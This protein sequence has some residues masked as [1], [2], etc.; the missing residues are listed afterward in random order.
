M[1]CFLPNSASSVLL[2]FSV[3]RLRFIPLAFL[4]AHLAPAQTI[5][6]QLYWTRL[7][8]SMP[9]N[10]RW[11]LRAE[12]DER[13]LIRP[14][15]QAQFIVHLQAARRL[16][17]HWE[18]GLTQTFS[19]VTRNIL[20]V[21]EWRPSSEITY[22][23]RIGARWRCVQRLRTEARWL[24]RNDGKLLLEGYQ[25]RARFRYRLQMERT[26]G[27]RWLLRLNDEIMV[28]HDGFDQNR[29]Y[30]SFVR[31]LSAHLSL[32]LGCLKVLQQRSSGG[33]VWQDVLRGTVYWRGYGRSNR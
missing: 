28:H 20:T 22:N 23:F 30:L 31:Q 10:T 33:L 26:L 27:T 19:A 8:F 15:R 2:P 9:L 29:T 13:R 17:A 25:L 1:R 12:A 32:E 5:H 21:P 14:D 6:Q 4:L 3:R 16:N 7:S 18:W 11:S 24:H